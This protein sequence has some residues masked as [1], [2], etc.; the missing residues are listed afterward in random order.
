MLY[1]F[2]LLVAHGTNTSGALSIGFLILLIYIPTIFFFRKFRFIRFS[3]EDTRINR[4]I[5]QILNATICA[6]LIS[7]LIFAALKLGQSDFKPVVS[8]LIN[9]E[10]FG[11]AGLISLIV[12]PL[13]W[14]FVD[15]TNWQRLL[16]VKPD[17]ENDQE[18]LHKN[19]RKGLLVY[20]IESP[21]TWIIFLFF[22]LLAVTALPHFT[23][24]DLLI[25][26]PKALINSTG[27]VQRFVGYTFIV[28]VLAIMLSTV[29]SFIVGIIF[30][31]VYDSYGQT[32]KLL[33]SQN[34]QDKRNNYSKITNAG[35]LFGLAAILFG[36]F[37]FIF[38]DKHVA[39]GG[40]L[41]INLLLT[42]YAAQLSFFPLIVGILFF[43]KHPSTAWANASM[44]TGAFTG[45][46]VGL[47]AVIW[48]PEYA[49]YPI[50]ICVVASMA[51]YLIGNLFSDH[52]TH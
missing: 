44:L 16:A 50:L 3:E 7:I 33:D 24:N 39:N 38:F 35:R 11:I 23:F 20:A 1:F 22:G 40:E 9:L 10:G 29:D 4:T 36:I 31:F 51:V 48:K 18:N 26:M 42:F 2:Y 6:L 21:F 8:H 13:C 49:W 28:S 12:L 37:F 45:I 52:G 5:N 47:Y 25:D 32:R 30:T 46:A 17:R 41:F 19:I 43:K 27:L 15:L 14:Q 34:E